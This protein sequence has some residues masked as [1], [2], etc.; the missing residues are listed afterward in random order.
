MESEREFRYTAANT[1][2]GPVQLVRDGRMFTMRRRSPVLLAGLTLALL[3]LLSACGPIGS[4]PSNEVDMG[5]AAFK[6]STI[7]I[8][9]GQSV[10]FVDPANGGGTHLLCVGKNTECVPQQGAPAALSMKDGLAFNP[11]DPPK[12][13]VFSTPGTYVVVCIIHPDMEVT[14]SV[15]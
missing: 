14:V 9:A 4:T 10:H 11:G 13:I 6:Q 7:S 1:R 3:A 8:K 2:D 15:R 12:D 5:V